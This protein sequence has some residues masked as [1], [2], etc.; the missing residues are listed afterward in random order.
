[1]KRWLE[2]RSY[3]LK[4]G[5]RVELHRVMQEESLPMLQRWGVDVVRCG[6]SAHDDDSYVL[7]RAYA[8]LAERQASQDAFYGSD[9]WRQGPRER[10][11]GKIEHYTS[12]VLEL[13]AT[14]IEGLREN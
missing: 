5:T 13:D 11:V 14:V 4:L 2:I 12:V 3:T 7:M 1:M 10:V 9:E 8:S 6:P